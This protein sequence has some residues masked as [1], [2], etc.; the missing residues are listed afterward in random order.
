MYMGIVYVPNSSELKKLILKEMHNVPYAGHLGYQKTI[1]T[2]KKQYYWPGMKKE[3]VDY[4]VKCLECQKVK[5]E[6]RHSVGLLQP[7]P[8][9]E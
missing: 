9:L 1:A 5:T 6:H 8:I 4:I 2:V 3:L 7:L